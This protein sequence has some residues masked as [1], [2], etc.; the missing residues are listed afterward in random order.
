MWTENCQSIEETRKAIQE[1]QDF[2]YPLIEEAGL[3]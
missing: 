3:S 1:A 2:L